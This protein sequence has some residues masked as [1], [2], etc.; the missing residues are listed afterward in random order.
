MTKWATVAFWRKDDRN[1]QLPPVV[2]EVLRRGR[3]FIGTSQPI[4]A[5]TDQPNEPPDDP[6]NRHGYMARPTRRTKQ[7]ILIAVAVNE[8]RPTCGS[9]TAKGER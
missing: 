3:A 1:S 5:K 9:A 7:P 8:P 2:E 6:A 4:P